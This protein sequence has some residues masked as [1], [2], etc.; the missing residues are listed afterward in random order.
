MHPLHR[1]PNRLESAMR[2]IRAFV[3]TGRWTVGHQDI[4]APHPEPGAER[5]H[6]GH[7]VPLAVLMWPVAVPDRAF[8][9][10]DQQPLLPHHPSIDLTAGRIIALAPR[11]I[12]VAA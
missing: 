1:P 12:V 7:H 10:G 5:Q 11:R 4:E 3:D 2:R 9:A 8:E 6:L